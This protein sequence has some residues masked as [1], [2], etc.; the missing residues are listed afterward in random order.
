MIDPATNQP[1]GTVPNMATEE[2]KAAVD[3]AAKTLPTWR[4]LTAHQRNFTATLVP[5]DTG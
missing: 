3:A 5:T 1:I 4:A 2:A